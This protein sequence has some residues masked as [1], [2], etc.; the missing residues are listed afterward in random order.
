MNLRRKFRHLRF[1]IPPLLLAF[2]PSIST[3]P[4][5][6]KKPSEF[7]LSLAQT[8]NEDVL[9]IIFSFLLDYPKTVANAASVC[10]NWLPVCR[11]QLY[12]GIKV[13][14]ETAKALGNTFR[15][16]PH[17]LG[18]VRHLLLFCVLQEEFEEIC[19]WLCTPSTWPARL[20]SL[21]V[22]SPVGYIAD[23]DITGL[24]EKFPD[25]STI[26]CFFTNCI[27]QP[28][29]WWNDW[30]PTLFSLHTL[31][32][33]H[34]SRPFDLPAELF[35][36][37]RLKRLSL[38]AKGYSPEISTLLSAVARTLEH[39]DL[40]I[41]LW[42]DTSDFAHTLITKLSGIR[43]L[44]IHSS[45]MTLTPFVDDLVAHLPH[46]E[47][48]HCADNMYSGKLFSSIPPSLKLLQLECTLYDPFPVAAASDAIRQRKATESQLTTLIVTRQ[49]DRSE[50]KEL[51]KVC[52]SV[53]L[54]FIRTLPGHI[55]QFGESITKLRGGCCA[56][57]LGG[58]APLGWRLELPYRLY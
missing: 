8:C 33:G 42:D 28:P 16:R 3:R 49:T 20:H 45:Q 56:F 1:H 39:L 58:R 24:F 19:E 34:R 11:A 21:E 14:S 31:Q 12:Q 32:L 25:L 36:L 10:R 47:S 22:V 43:H 7:Q 52:E 50:L 27:F 2:L 53:G 6:N 23:V 4:S 5:R 37:P 18:H 48:L 40:L 46:L 15:S 30:L 9:F 41:R 13:T 44:F 54:K 38:A 17:L 29:A 26:R 55:P 57:C 51:Q 35:N